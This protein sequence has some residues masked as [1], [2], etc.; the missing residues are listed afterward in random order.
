ME[1]RVYRNDNC[2]IEG[3]DYVAVVNSKECFIVR[4]VSAKLP[5]WKD[6][7]I[8]S[9][10]PIPCPADGLLNGSVG[11]SDGWHYLLNE[12]DIKQHDFSHANKGVTKGEYIQAMIPV[13][14]SLKED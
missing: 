9:V 11:A 13:A 7:I 14:Q 8:Q 12:G 4:L 1:I 3:E 5:E 2:M 6:A 10:R